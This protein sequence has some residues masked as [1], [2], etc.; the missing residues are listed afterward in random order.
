[1]F[2]VLLAVMDRFGLDEATAYQ[3]LR[4]EAMNQRLS[5]EDLS[6][7]IAT[8]GSA[9]LDRLVIRTKRALRQASQR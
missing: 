7:S 6:Q 8:K 9:E 5:I 3:T 2:K 4:R 1:V